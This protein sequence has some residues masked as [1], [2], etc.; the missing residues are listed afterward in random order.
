MRLIDADKLIQALEITITHSK[1]EYTDFESEYLDGIKQGIEAAIEI[2]KIA[3]TLEE[4]KEGHW[5]KNDY[6]AYDYD[7]V[8]KCSICGKEIFVPDIKAAKVY[9]YDKYCFNCGSKMINQNTLIDKVG[10]VLEQIAETATNFF[11]DETISGL[12]EEGEE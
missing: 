10:P 12:L 3:P 8:F 2:V 1:D 11:E 4:R 5:I 7:T 9:E 6:Q